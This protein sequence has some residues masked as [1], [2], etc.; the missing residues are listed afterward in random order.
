VTSTEEKRPRGRPKLSD[1]EKAARKAQREEAK[2]TIAPSSVVAVDAPLIASKPS[3]SMKPA[4]TVSITLTEKRPR[5]R[6]KLS[7]EEKA[8]RKAAREAQRETSGSDSDA[9]MKRGPGRPPLS[10]EEKAR[11]QAEREA[12]KL[13]ETG[14]V[15]RPRGRPALSEEEK[16]AR[17]LA[18]QEAKLAELRKQMERIARKIVRAETK[19]HKDDDEFVD[20]RPLPK[21][22][23]EDSET[24]DS[25][26]DE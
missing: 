23:H 11:R 9:T 20:A 26:D 4:P 18:R 21:T 12:R 3:L 22:V 7:D 5:G 19:L 2:A 15:K 6:P 17:K 14:G 1:E 13:A 16:S 10:A 24:D 8:A 25:E